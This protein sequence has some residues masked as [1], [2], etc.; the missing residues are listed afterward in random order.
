MTLSHRWGTEESFT[1]TRSTIAPF[2]HGIAWESIPN[3]FQQAITLVRELGIDYIW[4]DSLCIIQDDIE[5]WNKESVRMRDVYGSS[6]LN[7]VANCAPDSKGNLWS[8][9]NLLNEHPTYPVNPYCSVRAQPHLTHTF[10]GS[11]HFME[12][13][14]PMLLHRGWV[15]QEL[16]ISPRVVYYDLK[17]SNGSAE[18][19]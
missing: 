10:Y 16:L 4:I 17:S 9:S 1:L 7:I 13:E 5:D 19:P 2:S 12:E 18:K 6:F 14:A 15:F 11:N 8:Y 3:L